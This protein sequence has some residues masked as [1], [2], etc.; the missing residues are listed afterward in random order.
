LLAVPRRAIRQTH[1][2]AAAAP[3]VQQLAVHLAA[4]PRAQLEPA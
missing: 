1:G 4:L 3:R 2:R